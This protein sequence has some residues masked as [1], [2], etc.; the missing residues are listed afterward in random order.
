M[1]TILYAM[2]VLLVIGG[3]SAAFTT[4]INDNDGYAF[5][6]TTTL[7]INYALNLA[8][9]GGDVRINGS[10]TTANSNNLADLTTAEVS[11]VS[12]MGATTISGTQWGY[13]GAL[14]QSLTTGSAATFATVNTGHG[15]NELYA[16]NQDVETTDSPTF[17]GGT[18]NGD[19]YATKIGSGIIPNRVLDVQSLTATNAARLRYGGTSSNKAAVEIYHNGSAASGDNF[20]IYMSANGAGGANNYAFYAADGMGYFADDVG[21]GTDSPSAKLDVNGISRVI[22]SIGAP[23]SGEGVETYYSS[24]SGIGGIQIYDRTGGTYTGGTLKIDAENIALQTNSGGNVGIGTS[25]PSEKLEVDGGNVKFT[26]ASASNVVLDLNADG[27]SND[28]SFRLFE[29]NVFK[30]QFGWDDSEDHIRIGTNS[31]TKVVIE[32]SG[33]VGIGTTSPSYL[34]DVNG[35]LQANDYYSGDGTQGYTGSCGSSTTL[36][37]KDGL[38]T[39]CS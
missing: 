38:I 17:A 12:N 27:T 7:Y 29:N 33:N 24:G 4:Q 39:G 10:I 31:G 18:F 36:T 6:D 16:M 14:D 30:S 3:V 35:A 11:Q 1:K 20:G 13:V 19:V 8:D 22:S 37:V 26:G 28:A 5:F 23:T 21:I 32:D 25:S 9:F 2:I 15:A 34:L